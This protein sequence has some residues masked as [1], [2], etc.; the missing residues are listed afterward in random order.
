[1]EYFD[2]GIV[3][4]HLAWSGVEVPFVVLDQFAQSLAKVRETDEASR[5]VRPQWRLGAE[6]DA[7]TA[8]VREAQRQR[9]T[10]SFGAHEARR[11][12]EEGRRTGVA[13]DVVRP[14]ERL[15]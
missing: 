11:G 1:M 15:D 5:P 9:V 3:T 13:E 6:E 8:V 2:A 7:G 10:G 14:G 4:R 12:E